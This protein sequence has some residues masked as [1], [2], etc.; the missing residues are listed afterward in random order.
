MHM[1]LMRT[2]LDIYM[3]ASYA[4]SMCTCSSMFPALVLRVGAE[5]LV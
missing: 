5:V 1:E 3:E 2:V 4:A